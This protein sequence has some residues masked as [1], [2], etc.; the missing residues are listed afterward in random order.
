M[1]GKQ[2]S[3]IRLKYLRVERRNLDIQMGPA[4]AMFECKIF[5]IAGRF[6]NIFCWRYFG[7]MMGSSISKKG[8]SDIQGS[9]SAHAKPRWRP[10]SNSRGNCE[11]G[12]CIITTD[13]RLVTFPS[14]RS[15]M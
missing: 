6:A 13:Q 15:S 5:M 14:P 11:C 8:R 4:E 2:P 10:G 7:H 9:E 1:I 3:E 12:N